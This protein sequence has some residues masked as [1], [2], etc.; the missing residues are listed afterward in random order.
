MLLPVVSLV[1]LTVLCLSLNLVV[2]YV[3]PS[4]AVSSVLRRY[5]EIYIIHTLKAASYIIAL[6][7]LWL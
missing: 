5:C 6:V 4:V 2:F 3:K 7:I 1:C